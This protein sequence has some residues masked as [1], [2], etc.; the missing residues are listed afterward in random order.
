MRVRTLVRDAHASLT[1]FR[2]MSHAAVLCVRCDGRAGQVNFSREYW[3]QVF[4]PSLQEF[5]EVS[6]VHGY[7]FRVFTQRAPYFFL[8]ISSPLYSLPPTHGLAY[9]RQ[10]SRDRFLRV[11]MC[12]ATPRFDLCTC[13]IRAWEYLLDCSADA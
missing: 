8:N 4:E 5:A 7:C 6:A 1:S 11:E 9:A 10:G 13:L 12:F 3:N 2:G